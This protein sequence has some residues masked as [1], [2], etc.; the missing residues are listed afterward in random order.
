MVKIENIIV[1]VICLECKS[2]Y[3]LPILEPVTEKEQRSLGYEYEHT[4]N[5]N[6]KCDKC[7]DEIKIEVIAYEYPKGFLNYEETNGEGCIITDKIN[8][9]VHDPNY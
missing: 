8:F 3:S 7:G 1:N 4:W 5:S 6:I 2:K 9:T